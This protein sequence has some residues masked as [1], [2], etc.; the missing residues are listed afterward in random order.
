MACTA[1]NGPSLGEKNTP[2]HADPGWKLKREILLRIFTEQFRIE[3]PQFFDN[4]CKQLRFGMNNK[5]IKIVDDVTMKSRKLWRLWKK[6]SKHLT[7]AETLHALSVVYHTKLTYLDINSPEDISLRTAEF[8]SIYEYHSDWSQR[9]SEPRRAKF[10]ELIDQELQGRAAV[11]EKEE[12]RRQDAQRQRESDCQQKKI[13]HQERVVKRRDEQLAKQ[14]K[15]RLEREKRQV[16]RQNK[17]AER[18]KARLRKSAGSVQRAESQQEAEPQQHAA[19]PNQPPAHNPHWLPLVQALQTELQS[20]L[21]DAPIPE[22]SESPNLVAPAHDDQPSSH[23]N[24]SA[25]PL[26]HPDP[27]NEEN[28]ESSMDLGDTGG[29]FENDPLFSLDTSTTA[30]SPPAFDDGESLESLRDDL[31]NIFGFSDGEKAYIGGVG[32]TF[33]EEQADRLR[34]ND[35]SDQGQMQVDGVDGN[36]E[37]EE[38]FG[39]LETQDT[40]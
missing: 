15:K 36:F 16:E 31:D 17:Q 25:T 35:I 10:Q 19:Q 24:T 32:D 34:I 37:E 3:Y 33:D 8:E 23:D 26:P 12:A 27:S 29:F 5:D 18:L 22:D 13:Q 28:A 38:D 6:I 39:L 4:H 1:K 40:A 7:A 21:S 11:W 9:A 14:A 2:F 30:F 20:H